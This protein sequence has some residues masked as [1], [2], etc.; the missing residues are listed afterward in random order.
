[1]KPPITGDDYRRAALEL[2]CA[3]A[4]I[5]AV[6][7]VESS[8]SGFNEDDSPKTLFEGHH[9]HRL[10]DGRYGSSHPTLSYPKWTREFY[11]RS[12]VDEKQRLESA[13]NLDFK[14]ALLAT[15]WGRFQIM[16][17][18][19]ALCGYVSVFDFVK[20]M[21][22]SETK[23]LDAFVQFIEHRGLADELRD[24]RWADF[25]RL[26][27]GAGYAANRYDEKLAR[28]YELSLKQYPPIKAQP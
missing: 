5:A 16:G 9:F 21:S 6:A 23:Q 8:G 1:M 22:T 28:A 25:A 24:L 17:F 14:A 27:N 10:T 7:Q 2:G 26:Y 4:A 12:W 13:K 3:T 18:N 11:G 19:Y 20:D 15:S